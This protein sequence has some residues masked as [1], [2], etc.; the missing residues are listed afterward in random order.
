MNRTK[1]KRLIVINALLA[2]MI[3]SQFLPGPRGLVGLTTFTL[4]L[5]QFVG[6]FCIVVCPVSFILFL[7]RYQQRESNDQVNYYKPLLNCT[8]SFTIFL[9]SFALSGVMAHIARGVAIRR[10]QPI[11]SAIESYKKDKGSYPENITS[12][13]PRYLSK[14][15]SPL[16]M[17]VSDFD[18]KNYG[19]RYTLHFVQNVLIWFNWE[20]VLYDPL[21]K[22]NLDDPYGD[23]V[24]TNYHHWKYYVYD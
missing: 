17:G 12:I 1:R 11:I 7:K 16:I 15:P 20:E 5:F 18:Y 14:I 9:F 19:D 21:D 13:T 6:L 8:V 23:F 2:V 22:H 3:S 10:A 24:S 4:C